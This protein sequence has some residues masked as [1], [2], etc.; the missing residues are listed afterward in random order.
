MR[1]ERVGVASSLLAAHRSPRCWTYKE[2]REG[3]TEEEAIQNIT[4][5]I[6]EYLAAIDDMFPDVEIRMIDVA[7]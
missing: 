1:R 5:A 3:N 2:G 4:D 7:E 6:H